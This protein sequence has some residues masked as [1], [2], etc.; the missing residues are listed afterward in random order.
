[1]RAHECECD[2]NIVISAGDRNHP[3][4]EERTKDREQEM[5]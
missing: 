4:P 1:M 3:S 2:R 5:N